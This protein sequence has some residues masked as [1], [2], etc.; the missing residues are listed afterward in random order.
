MLRTVKRTS[1]TLR[2]NKNILRHETKKK[3]KTTTLSLTQIL[4]VLFKK[5][6]SVKVKT[7]EEKL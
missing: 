3:K 1:E 6:S 7:L 5:F 4:V 2:Q